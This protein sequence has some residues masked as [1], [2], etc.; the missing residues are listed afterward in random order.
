MFV[1]CVYV[2]TVVYIWIG[3]SVNKTIY[4]RDEDVPTWEKA[5]GLAGDKLSPIIASA[6]KRY[7]AE[8]EWKQ[9]G[10]ER[11]EYEYSDQDCNGLPRRKAFYGR[12]IFPPSKPYGGF[13][14]KRQEFDRSVVALTAKGYVI[15]C[16]W[17]EGRDDEGNDWASYKRFRVF[18]SFETGA[19]D[20]SCSWVVTSAIRE[21]GV[22]VEELDV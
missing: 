10:F 19:Q 21:V 8:E 16:T 3:I 4:V 11:I 15:V 18:R 7:V 20:P 6:L 5:K 9:K 22:P 1:Y 12:W 14:E 2:C 13:S 17:T